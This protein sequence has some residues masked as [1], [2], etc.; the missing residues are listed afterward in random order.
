MGKTM[1]SLSPAIR[2][3]RQSVFI[4]LWGVL[5]LSVSPALALERPSPAELEQLRQNPEEFLRRREKAVSFGNHMAKPW[6][7]QRTAQKLTAMGSGEDIRNLPPPAWRGMPT[8]GTNKVLVLLVDF[9]DYP[10]FNS[11]AT[12]SNKV[13]GA[14]VPGDFPLESL[15]K[16]YSRA[17]YGQLTIKGSVLG[18][19]RMA[20]NRSWYEPADDASASEQNAAN[21]AVIREVVDNFDASI[22]YSQF[23][24]NAD[25]E[26]DYFAILWSGPDNGWANFWWGYQWDLYQD[27][28]RDG[29]RF[30]TFSWQWESNPTYPPFVADYQPNV[31]I[32]ETGHALGLPDYYDYDD[33]VG[34]RGGVGGLDMM[35]SG[36]H[37]HNCFSKFMLDWIVP[38]VITNSVEDFPLRASA[39]YPE[40]VAL[41]KGYT[42]TSCFAEFYMVQNRQQVNNDLDLPGTGLLVWHIDSRLTGGGADFLFDNS[43]AEHKLLRLMEADGLEEIE[44]ASNADAGDFYA[45]GK[46]FTPESTPNSQSYGGSNTEVRV[47]DISVSAATMTA[48]YSALDN[49]PVVNPSWVYVREGDV[50]NAEM[51]LFRQP[52]GTATLSI[53]WFSGNTNLYIAAGSNLTFD[54]SNW[55]VPQLFTVGSFNDADSNN[56]VAVFLVTAGGGGV[57]NGSFP[58]EQRD[59]GDTLPPRCTITGLANV[60]RTEVAVD[61]QFDESVAGF[62]TNDIGYSDNIAGGATLLDLVDVSG[63]NHLFRAR[64]SCADVLGAISLVVPAG[65]LTDQ[66]GNSNPNLEYRGIYTLPW[67]KADFS[68]DFDGAVT[69]WT[70]STNVYAA[71][72]TDG[73]RWGPPVFDPLLW[74]GPAAA[75]SGSNCWGTMDGPYGVILDAWLEAPAIE[76]RDNPVLSFQLWMGESGKAYVE[77]NGGSGWRSVVP[78]SYYTST[79]S[80]WSRREIALDPAHF[81]N[82]SIE[83]RFRAWNCAM[84]VDDVR[85]ESWRPASAW[86][87][88]GTPTNG[89]P[90]TTVPVVLAVYNSTLSTLSNV[91]GEVSCPDAGVTIAGGVPVSYSTVVPGGVISG[92]APVSVQLAS[93]GSFDTPVVHLSHQSSIGGAPAQQDD[94]P[95]VVDGVVILPATNFLTVRS[96]SGVTNWMGQRLQGNGGPTSCIFQVIYAGADGVAN[97]PADNGQVTGDD[98][99]LYGSGSLL[100]WGRFGEGSGVPA[101]LGQFTATFKHNLPASAKVF[102]RAWD[103]ASYVASV[104]YGDSSLYTLSGLVSQD[105]DFGSWRVGSPVNYLRDSNGDS[106]PDGWS[107]QYGLDA[108]APIQPLGSQV[109]SAKAATGFNYPSRVAVSSNFVFVAD[110]ENDRVQVWDR[111]L[112]SQLFVLGVAGGSEFGKPRGIAVSRDGLR[113]AVADTS[114]RRV[115]VFSVNPANGALTSLFNFG[116]Y[117]TNSGAFNDPMAVAFGASREI[118]VAD[119]QQSGTCNNR[120]QIFETNGVFRGTFGTAG[121]GD[122]EFNRLLGVGMGE[123]GVLYAADGVNHRVQA[124]AGGTNFAWEFGALGTLTGEFNRVWDAQPGVAGRLYVTD[125]YNKRIQV[126]NTAN[127][128]V[129]AVAANYTNAGTLGVFNLPESAAP[130]PDDSLLY[131]ADTYNNRVLRLRVT[132][133]ADSDGMDDVWESLHG[134]D[135]NNPADSTEDPDGDGVMNI[136]EY[137]VGTDA[138]EFDT[139]NNGAGDGWELANGRDPVATGGPSI[140][141]PAVVLVSSD[142]VAPLRWGRVVRITATFS[143]TITNTPKLALS[144]AVSLAAT[145]MAGS[146]SSW[147]YDY[148]VP[149]AVSGAVNVAVS[150][151]IGANGYLMD[152]PTV[153]V[154]GLFY[155]D[156]LDFSVVSIDTVSWVLG[157][158]AWSG[159]VFLLQT[160]TNLVDTNWVTSLTLTSTVNGVLTVTNAFS[161]TNLN[162]FLRVLWMNPP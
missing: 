68:D 54:T 103:S 79:E 6:V 94:F 63:S 151:G 4:C 126:L 148:V 40:A 70:P 39:D 83:I 149:N 109:V 110:T 75:Y 11:Y 65:S 2:F 107:V 97:P 47:T 66:S 125:F 45:A 120:V 145:A 141:P 26:V 96:S 77:V 139:N 52:T 106:V 137:R 122:A 89:A 93:A 9:P 31:I 116:A 156:G 140:D 112:N 142:A 101:N 134:L 154:N 147:Y 91:A 3:T 43:Y 104:A 46:V 135:P 57:Q 15:T 153:T 18:W 53:A 30:K 22:D 78:G 146:G 128:P 81:A 44:N 38:T 12:V 64:F 133:D 56:D 25:G 59:I 99:P 108:R 71:I 113:V 42:G 69:L 67:V 161:T 80:V 48:D 28:W 152:P 49:L 1:Y 60:G 74:S 73:W 84:Y 118:Y 123:D 124:F 158:Q 76:V 114:K 159:D 138:Q 100:P 58:V 37:D 131:V 162:E 13:L 82:R 87:A 29:V 117:G 19:Y 105:H 62:D 34:P 155:I 90:G 98:R 5:A 50:T 121:A 16:F 144:G 32:H 21:Y 160:S 150:G 20:H 143:Q 61:F 119:S 111:G 130:A 88:S 55:N 24:N 23:D 72:T 157:W 8:S 85:V 92:A 95:L 51:T 27:L 7:I 129:I 35:D 10:A 132:M 127:A 36:K 102:V 14:G 115:R 86:L 41:T 136:G 33:S 17:S